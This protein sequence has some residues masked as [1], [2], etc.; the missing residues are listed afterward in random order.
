MK[1]E[2]VAEEIEKTDMY[3]YMEDVYDVMAKLEEVLH[4]SLS[5]PFTT[6]PLSTTSD[7]ATAHQTKVKIPKLYDSFFQGWA[8]SLGH[9]LGFM[10]GSYPLEQLTLQ[11]RRQVLGRG[12]G[13]QGGV[14][15]MTNAGTW[16]NYC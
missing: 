9:L 6:S 3:M 15:N 10:R 12:G 14:K 2:E 1:E 16:I 13:A 7:D 8:D 5:R 4:K 11:G